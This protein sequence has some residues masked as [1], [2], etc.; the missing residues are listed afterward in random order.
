LVEHSLG[1]GEVTSSILVIG[2]R[3]EGRV[4]DVASFEQAVLK[5]ERER[6]FAELKNAI[7]RA[8]AADQVEKLLKRLAREKVRIR[9]WDSVLAR[10]VLDEGGPEVRARSLYDLLPVS[11]QAQ[12]REFYLFQLEEVS[13]KLRARFHRLYQY[14]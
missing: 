14:Y 3:F 1:K 5:V 12:I 9:D 2:S 13:P 7:G 6:E 10:G 11:D 8:F 4:L